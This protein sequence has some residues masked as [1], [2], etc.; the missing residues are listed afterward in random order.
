MER[1]EQMD[2][3]ESDRDGLAGNWLGEWLTGAAGLRDG[4]ERP[5]P[6]GVTP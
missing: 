5:T 6:A 1:I 3:W 2:G 4:A